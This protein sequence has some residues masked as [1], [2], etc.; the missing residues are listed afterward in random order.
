MSNDRPTGR[1][2]AAPGVSAHAAAAFS[3]RGPGRQLLAE[4]QRMGAGGGAVGGAA[5]AVRTAAARADRAGAG[6]DIPAPQPG[7]LR[8]RRDLGRAGAAP[9]AGT[10]LADAA[11]REAHAPSN[12]WCVPVVTSRRVDDVRRR[13]RSVA[14]PRGRWCDVVC[15]VVRCA[16]R[17]LARFAPPGLLRPVSSQSR[18]PGGEFIRRGGEWWRFRD[19]PRARRDRR[20]TFGARTPE[21]HPSHGYAG[22]NAPVEHR[23]KGV[24]GIRDRVDVPRTGV[25]T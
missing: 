8:H 13:S 21:R 25:A 10:H 20:I 3:Q 9:G 11:D 2:S 23:P 4:G 14:G 19:R 5:R 1:S 22:G 24:A 6:D 16:A 12:G 7:V 17:A 18:E 15:R